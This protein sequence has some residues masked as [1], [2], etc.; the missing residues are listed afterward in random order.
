MS[1]DLVTESVSEFGRW[2]PKTTIPYDA[3]HSK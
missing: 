3:T 2:L 1:Q